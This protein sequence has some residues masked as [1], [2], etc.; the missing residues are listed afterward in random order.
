MQLS[1]FTEMKMTLEESCAQFGI[2]PRIYL[3]SSKSTDLMNTLLTPHSPNARTLQQL[4]PPFLLLLL[5]IGCVPQDQQQITR[6][7]A[8]RSAMILP[9]SLDRGMCLH[10][11]EKRACIGA[12]HVFWHWCNFR[13]LSYM[14]LRFHVI[15][16]PGWN[17]DVH[18]A[19]LGTIQEI[20]LGD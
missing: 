11:K 1:D 14:I 7:M 10:C 6:G 8:Q 12:A 4:H 2:K 16:Q 13:V 3:I 18:S 15:T 19:N 5:R 17:F 20:R 9:H